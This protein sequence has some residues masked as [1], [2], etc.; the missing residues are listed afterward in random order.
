MIFHENR[1]LHDVDIC[2][3]WKNTVLGYIKGSKLI[4]GPQF[5]GIMN[6]KPSSSQRTFSHLNTTPRTDY[7][8]FANSSPYPVDL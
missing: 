2:I 7:I 4:C 3:K 5:F 8:A 1:F 6:F